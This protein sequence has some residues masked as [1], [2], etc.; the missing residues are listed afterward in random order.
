MLMRGSGTI[1]SG[2]VRRWPSTVR[3]TLYVPGGAQTPFANGLLP[4]VRDE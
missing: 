1:V 4:A 3:T 2:C